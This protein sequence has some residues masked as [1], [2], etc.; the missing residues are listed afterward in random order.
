MLHDRRNVLPYQRQIRLHNLDQCDALQ[1]RVLPLDPPE[2]H[3]HVTPVPLHP[4]Q[5]QPLPTRAPPA[6]ITILCPGRKV[7]HVHPIRHREDGVLQ[8]DMRD[9]LFL[10]GQGDKRVHL[11]HPLRRHNNHESIVTGLMSTTAP[12]L[13][14]LRKRRSFLSSFSLVESDKA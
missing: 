5:G 2:L 14:T 8:E 9:L 12:S 3:V 4:G 11:T 6:S 13:A 7:H 10:L 1:V